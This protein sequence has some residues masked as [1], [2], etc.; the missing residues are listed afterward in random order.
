MKKKTTFML[1]TIGVLY[2]GIYWAFFDMNRLPKGELISEL[3]SPNGDYTIKAYVSDGGATTDFSVL[4]ELNYNA[5]NKKTKNI[6]WNY[7]EDTANIEWVDDDTVII[8]GHE[9]NVLHD[10][11]DFRISK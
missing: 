3:K 5:M 2:Y 4:G 6:Y 9:L 8:N 1:S 11:F 10:T 7:H